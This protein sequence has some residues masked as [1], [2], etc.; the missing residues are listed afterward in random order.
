MVPPPPLTVCQRRLAPSVPRTWPVTG[1]ATG[2]SFACVTAL[3]AICVL[4]MVPVRFPVGSVALP[5][6]I[7][8]MFCAPATVAAGDS[9]SA[10]AARIAYALAVTGCRGFISPSALTATVSQYGT[11]NCNGGR[12]VTE[13]STASKTPLATLTESWVSVHS[14]EPPLTAL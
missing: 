13:P 8:P 3:L 2:E 12:S 7:A 9:A 6:V 14:A 5:L 10:L 1:G 11:S 4:P